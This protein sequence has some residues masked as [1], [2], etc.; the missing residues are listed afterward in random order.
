MA[1]YRALASEG[2]QRNTT[3]RN[4]TIE[5]GKKVFDKKAEY[6]VF[7]HTWQKFHIWASLRNSPE[8]YSRHISKDRVI[9]DSVP[10]KCQVQKH[11]VIEYYVTSAKYMEVVPKLSDVVGTLFTNVKKFAIHRKILFVHYLQKC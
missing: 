5:R 2:R 4:P 10:W 6:E 3:H 9:L 1:Q 7:L 11:I 8:I